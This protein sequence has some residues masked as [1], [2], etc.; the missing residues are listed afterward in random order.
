MD[1]NALDFQTK[2]FQWF[3]RRS[4]QIIKLFLI[5]YILIITVIFLGC[6]FYFTNRD[7]QIFIYELGKNLGRTAILMLGIVVLPGILGRFR[8]EIKLTRI[9]TLFRRQLG[10]C[11]F[12]LAF[13][14]F[15]FVRML[16]SLSFGTLPIFNLVLFELFGLLA[17][18]ILFFMFL[19]SNNQSVKGLGK[20]W[21]RLHR[22]IYL[23]LWLLVLHTGFQ[24]ISLFSTYIFF[25]ATLEIVSWMYYFATKKTPSS[26]TTN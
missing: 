1:P 8:V 16:T 20:W 2:V 9:I 18:T 15:S 23:A 25:F 26:P 21:K 7:S 4:P 13:A 17:L 22:F 3:A 10:I 19:T 5:P 6:F 12:L 24:R 14:H 11:I